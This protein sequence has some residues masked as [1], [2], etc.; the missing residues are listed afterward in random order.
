MLDVALRRLAVD[1]ERVREAMARAS[2]RRDR[3]GDTS[4]SAWRRTKKAARSRTTM[5]QARSADAASSSPVQEKS[6]VPTP[7]KSIPKDKRK[8]P[9]E[10]SEGDGG[11]TS[12]LKAAR[13]RAKKQ[14]FGG[15]ED[16]E[17]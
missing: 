2:S 5:K 11:M 1:P 15:F 9:D 17:S 16:N 14:G 4:L 7:D 3:K 6:S 8:Q 13:D 10:A 12:R